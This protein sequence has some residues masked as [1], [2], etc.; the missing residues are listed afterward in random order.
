V[1]SEGP[2]NAWR[3]VIAYHLL[4]AAL[5][6]IGGVFRGE[7]AAFLR[8]LADLMI[9]VASFAALAAGT[10]DDV[11]VPAWVLIIYPL[12]LAAVAAAYGWL[13]EHPPGVVVAAVVLLVWTAVGGSRGYRLLRD[14]VPG[15][16][17]LA[18]SFVL[19]VVAVV[20]S[21]TKSGHLSRWLARWGVLPA[22]APPPEA[23]AVP[24]QPQG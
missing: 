9:I 23:P 21:L 5:L 17:Q 10:H 3:A 16:N 13:V 24:G 15:L 12:A 4:L 6:V 8:T 2:V 14:I 20:V 7:L 22:A 11:G 19:F 1:P 18:L